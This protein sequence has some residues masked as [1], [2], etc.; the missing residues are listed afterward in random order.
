[1]W[2]RDEDRLAL[3]ELLEAGRLRRRSGQGEAW[4][5]LDQLPWTRRTGRRDEFGLVPEYQHTLVQLLDRVWPGWR[6]VS[7][8]LA[9][10]GLGPTPTGWRRLQDL[11]RAEGL[12]KLPDRL[13][14][15]TA[16]SAVGPHSKATLSLI[17]STALGDVTTTGDGMV[18][19]RAPSGVCLVRGKEVLDATTVADVLGEVTITERAL[20]DGTVLAGPVRAALLVENLGAYE[21]LEP[22]NGWLIIHVP[23]WNTATLRLFLPQLGEVPVVHFG[24]LDPA[25]IR[26][27]RHLREIHPALIWAVPD[28]WDEYV[29]RHALP[30]VWPDDLKLDGCPALVRKLATRR[31]WLEQEVIAVDPRLRAALETAMRRSINGVL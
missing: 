3:L 9:E 21:D 31:L 2:D 14:R 10:R 5:L 25:G 19:L 22:P 23:G 11:L 1:M 13:N 30:G 24:D 16:T 7:K 27:I 20:L 18:R 29:D 28:F 4:S 15:R 6:L 8:A 12:A 26:I 17:R